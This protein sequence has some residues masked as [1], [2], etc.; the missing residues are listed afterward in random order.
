MACTTDEPIREWK[1]RFIGKPFNQKNFVQRLESYLQE[2]R[3]D[4]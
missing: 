1:Q 2:G 4:R 3:Y